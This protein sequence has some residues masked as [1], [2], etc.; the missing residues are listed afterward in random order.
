MHGSL[1]P[2][3]LLIHLSQN[4][5]GMVDIRDWNIKP[6]P[7]LNISKGLRGNCFGPTK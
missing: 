4:D 6:P 1:K 5:Q 7:T 3:M 2:I